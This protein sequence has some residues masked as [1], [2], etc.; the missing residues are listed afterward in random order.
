M[1][2]WTKR[3]SRRWSSYW[4]RTSQTIASSQRKASLGSTP[5]RLD[6]LCARLPVRWELQRTGDS[7]YPFICERFH[8]LSCQLMS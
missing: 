4:E 8:L 5:A 7:A 2:D 3:R 6:R 1:P